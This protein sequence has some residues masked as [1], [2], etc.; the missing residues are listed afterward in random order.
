MRYLNKTRAILLV[1]VIPTLFN[2]LRPLVK[3]NFI[4]IALIT[5]FSYGLISLWYW[6]VLEVIKESL[7]VN[8]NEETLIRAFLILLTVYPIVA[9]V[10]SG[11]PDVTNVLLIGNLFFALYGFLS[12]YILS[13]NLE[14]L[15]SL[16]GIVIDKF[17]NFI[18]LAVYPIG[19]WKYQDGLIKFGKFDKVR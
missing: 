14:K 2:L 11:L 7:E 9:L 5:V 6:K 4:I 10:I 16:R 17:W 15:L 3:D 8:R 12:L 1:F 13:V 18:Y 19:I